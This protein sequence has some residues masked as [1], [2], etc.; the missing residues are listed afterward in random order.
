MRK[1][2]LI[3]L[4]SFAV[5]VSLLMTVGFISKANVDAKN[6]TVIWADLK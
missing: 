4:F 3:R 5:I 6:D 2:Y 1:E